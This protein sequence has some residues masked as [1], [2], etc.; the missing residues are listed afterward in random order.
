V[1][2]ASTEKTI[3]LPIVRVTAYEDRAEVVREGEVELAPGATTL[4]LEGLTPLC[5]DE[6]IVASIDSAEDAH[7]DDVKVERSWRASERPDDKRAA[8]LAAKI[9]DNDVIVAG[10]GRKEARVRERRATLENLMQRWVGRAQ[11]ALSRAFDDPASPATG[12]ERFGTALQA[13]D[14]ELARAREEL[15]KAKKETERL[16]ALFDETKRPRDDR[17]VADLHV[18]VTSGGAKA[19]LKISYVV[20]CG[21][22]R[23]THEAA[24]DDG[25]VRWRTFATVWQKTGEDWRDVELVLS[26]ARPSAGAVLPV[27]DEDV[28]LLRSKTAEER[29]TIVV[30]H[31]GE[32]IPRGDL[33]GAAPGVYDGGE[34]RS[35][36][37]EGAVTIPSDG[38]PHRVG[39]GEMSCD[40][41]TAL[42]CMPEL[43]PHVFT[44]AT[45]T[46]N[47]SAPLLAGPVTLRRGGAYVGTGDLPYVGPGEEFE[48]GFGSEDAFATK[49]TRTQREQDR[50]LG[51]DRTHFVTEVDLS[52]TGEGEANVLVLLRMPK[53]ELKQLQIVPTDKYCSEGLPEP[54]DHGVVTLPVTLKPG[55]WRK[56]SLGFWFDTSGDVRIP[57]PW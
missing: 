23:P 24:L 26:T 47:A 9:R 2:E 11:R 16:R 29:K 28:L 37:A 3:E 4:K 7:V 22:W 13:V 12:L 32:A 17:Y 43:Q 40:A 52:Y 30:E 57:D 42:V 54:D 6:R 36:T 8:E 55:P 53:S 10:L 21:L 50:M 33:K 25:K 14:E 34:A 49:L 35:F 19:R 46:N 5:S 27:L 56:V 38:R 31:R 45:L 48:L 39:T 1:S 18:R 51:K 20:P 41:S 44:R 15:A